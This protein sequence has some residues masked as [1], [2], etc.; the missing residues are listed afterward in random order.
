[1]PK[2]R[3]HDAISFDV[4]LKASIV[5]YTGAYLVEVPIVRV[6]SGEFSIMLT[7]AFDLSQTDEFVIVKLIVP[8]AK[9]TV[10]LIHCDLD[11]SVRIA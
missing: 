9:V 2:P 5:D 10:R 4:Q 6:F 1:M 11:S 3:S 7:P 8:Y